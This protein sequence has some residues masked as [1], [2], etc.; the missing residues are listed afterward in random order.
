MKKKI[1][2]EYPFRCTPGSL[3]RAISTPLGLKS[4]FADRVETTGER[5]DFFWGKS[6]QAA[7]IVHRKAN[8]YVRFQW[9]EPEKHYL[10]MRLVSQELTGDILLTI[11]DFVDQDEIDGEREL[12][13]ALVEK[14]KRAIGCPK[15]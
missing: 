9:E 8:A 12:W 5:Y 4:W 15:K 7:R 2:L 10:E 6:S 1:V 11:T 13:D 14:L 3:F